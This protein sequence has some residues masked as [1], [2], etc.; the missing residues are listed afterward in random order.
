MADALGSWELS[1]EDYISLILDDLNGPVMSDRPRVI[2]VLMIRDGSI[3]GLCETAVDSVLREL[4]DPAR[5]QADHIIERSC[6]GPHTWENLRLTHGF[7]NNY[8]NNLSGSQN[9]PPGSFRKAF[10]QA[11]HRWENPHIYLPASIAWDEACI[12]DYR[13]KLAAAERKHRKLLKAASNEDDIAESAIAVAHWA[14]LIKS[15]ETH[16]AGL[17]RRIAEHLAKETARDVLARPDTPGPE[18]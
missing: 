7:C 4:N 14:K 1:S 3:C 5:P 12:A 16:R 2:E 6:G 18:H 9:T 15:T 17:E 13:K 11:V 10:E 8:R